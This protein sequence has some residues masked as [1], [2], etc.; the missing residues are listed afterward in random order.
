MAKDLR[1]AYDAADRTETHTPLGSLAYKL[2]STMVTSG[3]ADKDFSS[4]YKFFVE[5]GRIEGK[6][7]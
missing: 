7:P 6:K 2:Y 1:L 3:F 4:V 5:D